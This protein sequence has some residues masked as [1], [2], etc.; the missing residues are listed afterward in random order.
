MLT[1]LLDAVYFLVLALSGFVIGFVGGMVG[2]VVGVVRYHVVISIETSVSITAGT[3][4]GVSTVGA[5]TRQYV[6]IV[7]EIYDLVIIDNDG[8]GATIVERY[9]DRCSKSVN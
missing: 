3:N 8:E 6:I 7:K 9:C 4:L 2:L 5:V 1:I